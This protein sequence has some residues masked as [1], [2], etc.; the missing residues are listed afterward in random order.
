VA[1]SSSSSTKKAAK[2][3]KSGSGKKIRFQG[4]TL[5]PVVVTAVVVLGLALVVYA[6]QGQP[7]VDASGAPQQSDHWHHAYGFYLC[8]TWVQ[9][10]GDA[11]QQG[12]ENFTQYQRSGIHSHDDGLI[13]WHPF[14][15][16][17]VGTNARLGVFLDTYGVELANDKLTFPESQQAALE[18]QLAAQDPSREDVLVWED[19]DKCTVD[20][21]E[22]NAELKVVV[23]SNFTDTDDGTTYIAD[24]D[25]IA[26]DRDQMVVVMAFVPDDTDVS[27]PPW[28]PELPSLGEIDSGVVNPN[29]PIPP[30]GSTPVGSAPSNTAADVPSTTE[31]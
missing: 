9:L 21:S 14:T 15:S 13:H 18:T 7:S 10:D 4:G 3:A 23:W 29:A 17:S 25:N 22:E 24:F 6:R 27:M 28:A 5:F 1:P 19:G 12:S 20:G 11:E 8:D 16:A 26:L 31:G 2:L 30:A